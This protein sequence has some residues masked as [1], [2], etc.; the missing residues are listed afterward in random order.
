MFNTGGFNL[1]NFNLPVNNFIFAQAS[2]AGVGELSASAKYEIIAAIGLEGSGTLSLTVSQGGEAA[3][4]GVG[5]ISAI[6]LKELYANLTLA[7][8]GEMI[9]DANAYLVENLTFTGTFATN[10]IIIIDS[11]NLTIKLNGVNAMTKITGGDYFNLK[12]GI[13]AIKYSDASGSRTIKIE[14]KK[15]DRWL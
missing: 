10:D 6:A 11:D 15:R 8:M 5:E 2:L 7:G 3:L 4:S 13:N 14:V 1:I 12:P 9:A